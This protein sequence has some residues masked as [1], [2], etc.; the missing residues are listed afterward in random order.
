MNKETEEKINRFLDKLD[1]A[2]KEQN[3][4]VQEFAQK[5]G[6]TKMIVYLWKKKQN[7]MSL[8]KY[9][10]ACRILNIQPE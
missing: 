1:S 4:S 7:T 5:M 2:L 6:V 3:M 10:D 9:F 8:D